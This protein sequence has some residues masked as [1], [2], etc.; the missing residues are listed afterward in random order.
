MAKNNFPV[1]CDGYI[2]YDLVEVD[3]L[4][5]ILKKQITTE[6]VAA[7]DRVEYSKQSVVIFK[8]LN[9]NTK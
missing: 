8:I 3:R 7:A 6:A 4:L 1:V 5:A 9:N 2:K